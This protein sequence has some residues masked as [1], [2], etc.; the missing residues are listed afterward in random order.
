MD[1]V[2]SSVVGLWAINGSAKFGVRYRVCTQCH[3]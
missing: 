3:S 1:L 2:Q